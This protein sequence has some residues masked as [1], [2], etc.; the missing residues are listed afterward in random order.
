MQKGLQKLR[1]YLIENYNLKERMAAL[2]RGKLYSLEIELTNAC[3]LS[4]EYCYARA[5]STGIFLPTRK[6]K[7]LLLQAKQYGIKRIVWLGGEPMLHPRWLEI[8][9]FSKILGFKNELWSNGTLLHSK[10]RQE[11][12]AAVDIFVLHLDTVFSEN[13]CRVQCGLKSCGK[14]HAAII[15]SFAELLKEGYPK[16]K[17][18]ITIT[19][20]REVFK[21][22][23]K[24]LTFF[25]KDLGVRTSTLIPVYKVGKGENLTA[26]EFLSKDELRKVFQMRANIENRPELMLLG[27]SEQCKHYQKSC[28]YLK[29]NGDV[30]PYAAMDDIVVGNVYNQNLDDILE[31]HFSQLSFANWENGCNCKIC[32]NSAY[33]CGTIAAAHIAKKKADPNCWLN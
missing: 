6:A 13:F 18:R 10:N 7:Q 27:S 14:M 9:S 19:L 2:Q 5:N 26:E 29:V 31:K 17:T 28:A 11:I 16:E 4:C 24:T 21:D 25:L 30:L 8:I 23:K 3:N 15:T 1:Q 22:V 20:T 33:C 12:K 32:K